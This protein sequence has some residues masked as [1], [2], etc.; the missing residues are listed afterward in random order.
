VGPGADLKPNGV[1]I[2]ISWR[3]AEKVEV[4]P[5][6]GKTLIRFLFEALLERKIGNLNGLAFTI[7]QYREMKCLLH[8]VEELDHL[9]D[10]KVGLRPA[11][12]PEGVAV[13]PRISLRWS[14]SHLLGLSCNMV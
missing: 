11:G 7:V 2:S 12:L 6:F 8:Q 13:H 3:Y 14:S 5:E 10:S 9:P 4:H 1:V